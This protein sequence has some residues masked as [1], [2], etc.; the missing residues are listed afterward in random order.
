MWLVALLIVVVWNLVAIGAG[1]SGSLNPQERTTLARFVSRQAAAAVGLS[2]VAL[3][4][5]AVGLFFAPDVAG[6]AKFLAGCC[7][8]LGGLVPFTVSVLLRVEPRGRG[9]SA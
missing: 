8:A 6:L 3:V 4:F 5:G 2:I 9:D 7:W 1:V